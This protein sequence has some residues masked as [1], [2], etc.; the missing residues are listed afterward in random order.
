MRYGINHITKT[1]FLPAF[2]AAFDASISPANIRGAF[3]GSGLIPFNPEAVISTLD[4]RLETPTPPP[5]N[6]L[7]W[8]SKTPSTTLE[9]TSQTVLISTKI[10]RHQSS[11]LS[12]ILQAVDQ[13]AKG[14]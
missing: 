5:A 8:E 12:P 1:E 11:S 14:A 9:L 6:N 10:T 13:L 2:K 3:R 7:P 4:V